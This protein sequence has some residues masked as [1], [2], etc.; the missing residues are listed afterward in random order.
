VLLEIDRVVDAA[1]PG[2][3]HSFTIKPVVYLSAEG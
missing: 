2:V 3:V 1:Q